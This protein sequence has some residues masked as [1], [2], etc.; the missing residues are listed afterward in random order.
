MSQV[1]LAS[2]NIK[3]QHSGHGSQAMPNNLKWYSINDMSDTGG[4]I[5]ITDLETAVNAFDVPVIIAKQDY[6]SFFPLFYS[7]LY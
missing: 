4:S 5:I 7:K 6:V 3:F 2:V 1:M